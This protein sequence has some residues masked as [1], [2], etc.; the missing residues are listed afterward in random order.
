M[1]KAILRIV[2]VFVVLIIWVMIKVHTANQL[3]AEYLK[4]G[5]TEAES[6]IVSYVEAGLFR[7]DV[8]YYQIKENHE[9]HNAE[10]APFR[11]L[12]NPE[13]IYR[14]VRSNRCASLE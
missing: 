13:N 14:N 1:E 5:Y 4:K 8:Y 7:P 9:K 2:A 12:S 10:V 6:T 11:E 3:Y